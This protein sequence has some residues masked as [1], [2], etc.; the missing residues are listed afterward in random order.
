MAIDRTGISSLDAGASDITYT[1]NEGPRSPQEEQQM[2]LAQLKEE[3]EQY[4]MEQIEIDPSKVLPF[5]EWYQATYEASR[6][7]VAGGGIARLGYRGGQ[8]VKNNSDGSRPGYQ[9]WSPGV[10]HSGSPT[11]GHGSGGHHRDG[12]VTQSYPVYQA[13]TRSPQESVARE[14]DAQRTAALQESRGPIGRP[15][16]AST[17]AME[18]AYALPK[19][20]PPSMRSGALNALWTPPEEEQEEEKLLSKVLDKGKTLASDFRKKSI[21]RNL[22]HV[23]KGRPIQ[24]AIMAMLQG[25]MT[26]EEF[27]NQFGVSIEGL[28]GLSPMEQTN[29][30]GKEMSQFDKDRL[31]EMA[32]VY[33][34]DYVSQDDWT[35]AFYGP[36][37][38]PV[39]DRPGGDQL[40]YYPRDVHPGTG[41]IT[42]VDVAGT[43]YDDFI[44]S[45]KFVGG[46]EELKYSPL[47]YGGRVPAAYGGIM[48]DD[49][50]RAYGLGSIFKKAKRAIKKVAKSKIGK[51]ALLYG[52]GTYLGGTKALGGTGW[53]GW[54]KFGSR[55]LDPMGKSG[56]A[57]IFKPGGWFP[58][59]PT[60]IKGQTSSVIKSLTEQLK[61]KTLSDTQKA[62]ILE[63]IK[64]LGG[65]GADASG[66]FASLLKAGMVLGP[67]AALKYPN[68]GAVKGPDIKGLTAANQ[69]KADAWAKKHLAEL[70][71]DDWEL[72]GTLPS[73]LE[74]GPALVAQG[75][76]IGYANGGDD[77]EEEGHRAA[78]LSAM[79]RTKAQEG[80]LMDMGG[81]EKDYRQEGGFVPIG[82]QEKADDVP[83]RLSKNEF[84]F[85]ADAVR[86]AG[87]GD[88]DAGAEVMEN[89]MENLERG[90]QVSEESQGLEGARNMFATAQRL[91]GVL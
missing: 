34:Q 1:G 6:Q 52:L 74:Y 55:L 37:G 16:V 17:A 83:A 9:G 23:A 11:G 91:E 80:G 26:E 57:N 18:D 39:P 84:V 50:R 4:R 89:V 13:P 68:F 21:L 31:S 58:T 44:E 28:I 8:L 63:T 3:Y 67:L 42:D 14:E 71:E 40:P 76:R 82:G 12:P 65:T 10:S 29:I 59:D 60:S 20:L 32:G 36:K 78:A 75:G 35:T 88:I 43:N 22:Y 85:T 25:T 27:E 15:T 70:D 49:G 79:Y 41:G 5:E 72:S 90:G 33:G 45:L 7:G 38:P 51:A 86:A 62:E 30:F 73:T 19:D 64:S 69:A 66:P 61:D 54:G 24:P 53:K 77:E 56:I 81:M 48:G 46:P 2:M 47:A 87:G